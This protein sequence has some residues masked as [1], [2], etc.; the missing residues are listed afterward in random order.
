MKLFDW[1]I[2]IIKNKPPASKFKQED[3]NTFDIFMIHRL[4]SMNPNYLELVDYVQGLNIDDKEKVYRI[5]CDL[6]PKSNK[7][8]F[9]YIKSKT[10][11]NGTTTATKH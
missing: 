8:Y 5:Y 1:P 2:E 4:L 11:Q 6:I 10:K 7:T 3:W 9:P